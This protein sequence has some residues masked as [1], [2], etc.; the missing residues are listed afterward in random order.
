MIKSTPGNTTVPEGFAVYSTKDDQWKWI[1]YCEEWGDTAAVAVGDSQK[2]VAILSEAVNTLRVYDMESGEL[3]YT[4]NLPLGSVHGAAFF[5]C[6]DRFMVLGESFVKSV[7]ILNTQTWQLMGPFDTALT[8]Y[9]YF[10]EATTADISP[11]GKRLFIGNTLGFQYGMIIDLETWTLL[12]KVPYMLCYDPE[13]DRVLCLDP[14]RQALV[15]WPVYDKE[16]L[17]AMGKEAL[18]GN[19]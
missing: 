10:V 9:S 15:A 11:D 1:G 17:I 12:A 18:T 7:A 3:I 13:T 6:Q 16:D 4:G 8:G 5:I 14:D 2:W 19:R